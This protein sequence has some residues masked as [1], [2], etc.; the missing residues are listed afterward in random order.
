LQEREQKAHLQAQ[1][2]NIKRDLVEYKRA[3]REKT[4]RLLELMKSKPEPMPRMGKGLTNIP[5]HKASSAK[6]AYPLPPRGFDPTLLVDDTY[7]LHNQTANHKLASK[8][9]KIQISIPQPK[10]AHES[11]ESTI[12]FYD[13][14][15][16][17]QKYQEFFC[18]ENRSIPI[19]NPSLFKLPVEF[20]EQVHLLEYSKR[21]KR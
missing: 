6:F 20:D 14:F 7:F 1:L 12:D 13:M 5:R 17:K 19:Q 3:E 11:K 18:E 4:E 15:G 10:F 21:R 16:Y 2:D 8:S 9:R